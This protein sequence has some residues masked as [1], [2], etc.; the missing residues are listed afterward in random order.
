MVFLCK[1]T[2][3]FPS[4]LYTLLYKIVR[5]KH[6]LFCSSGFLF[7]LISFRRFVFIFKFDLQLI[8]YV[9]FCLLCIINVHDYFMSGFNLISF[10]WISKIFTLSTWLIETLVHFTSLTEFQYYFHSLVSRLSLVSRPESRCN[11]VGEVEFIH[12]VFRIR[13]FLKRWSTDQRICSPTRLL[14]RYL[15]FSFEMTD[16]K[17]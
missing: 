7:N 5:E 15:Y 8:L 6:R 13:L 11:D 9:L 1:R 16:S 2:L 12:S 3:G 4:K 10:T 17:R 14:T